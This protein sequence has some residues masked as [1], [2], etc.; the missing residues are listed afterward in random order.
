ML[1][2]VFERPSPSLLF[3]LQNTTH[4]FTLSKLDVGKL[5]VVYVCNIYDERAQNIGDWNEYQR[6]AIDL[7]SIEHKAL[8][9]SS[10]NSEFRLATIIIAPLLV[11]IFAVSIVITLLVTRRIRKNKVVDQYGMEYT[12]DDDG[13]YV[14]LKRKYDH[15]EIP[16]RRLQ[17]D[18]D[19]K[20]GAGAFGAVYKGRATCNT[21]NQ[22]SISGISGRIVGTLNKNRES[23]SVL[24][25]Y[26]MQAEN[27]EVAVK[28][29][30]GKELML[31]KE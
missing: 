28:M 26:W 12:T 14:T 21:V 30:P 10:S 16:R 8:K 25:E 3:P 22:K 11:A 7:T 23:K 15:W 29:L 13:R 31:V 27:C 2:M 5:Y 24:A 4:N 6:Y 20:L 19:R 18:Q 17:I 9:A 1:S